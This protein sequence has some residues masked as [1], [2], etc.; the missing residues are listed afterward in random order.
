MKNGWRA[1]Y[2]TAKR[3]KTPNLMFGVLSKARGRCLGRKRNN[4][5]VGNNV[6]PGEAD[7]DLDPY[8]P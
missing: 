4:R 2:D 6:M 1:R 3:R 5:S 8:H 7:H